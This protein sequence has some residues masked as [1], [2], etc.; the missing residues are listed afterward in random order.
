MSIQTRSKTMGREDTDELDEIPKKV[1]GLVETRDRQGETLEI[2]LESC[3]Q[4]SWFNKR[5]LKD[6]EDLKES[7]SLMGKEVQETKDALELKVS[8]DHV[9]QRA[10]KLDDLENR[11]RRN[12]IVIWGLQEN[13]E[14]GR[15]IEKFLIEELFLRHMN[16][17]GIEVM[18]AHRTNMSSGAFSASGRRPFSVKNPGSKPR[19]IHVYLLRY[20]DKTKILK[21]AAKTLKG[22]EFC[23][24]KLF[25]SDDVSKRCR[26]R[27]AQLRGEH[28]RSIQSREDVELAYIPWLVPAQILYKVTGEHRIKSFKLLPCEYDE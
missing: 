23:G 27:R 22:K 9:N 13:M 12:N 17:E 2:I 25:I 10:D 16:L 19:P 28:L 1:D 7:V 18:L 15:Q 26:D 14:E 8:R 4:S 3:K 21:P 6:I 24:W 11:S 5:P 20:T